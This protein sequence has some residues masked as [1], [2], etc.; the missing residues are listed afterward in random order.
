MADAS[1]TQI[2]GDAD[3]GGVYYANENTVS[4][5]NNVTVGGAVYFA[6]SADLGWN[7]NSFTVAEGATVAGAEV[8]AA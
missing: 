3:V 7:D 5:G 8:P 4:I 6:G 1:V 2:A